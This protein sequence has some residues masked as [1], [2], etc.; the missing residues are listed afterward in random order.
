MVKKII[1][2]LIISSI[3]VSGFAQKMKKT[4][5]KA[6][7]H[8]FEMLINGEN[9]PAEKYAPGEFIHFDFDVLDSKFHSYTY[10]WFDSYYQTPIET[11]PIKLV[12]PM[13][14]ESAGMNTYTVTLS[15]DIR[16][17][18]NAKPIKQDIVAKINIDYKRTDIEVKVSPGDDIT[19]PTTSHGDITFKSVI[20]EVYTP[21]DTVYLEKG[22]LFLVRWHITP[23]TYIKKE[24]AVTSCGD[25]VWGDVTVARPSGFIGDFKTEVERFFPATNPGDLD[26]LKILT[27]TIVNNALLKTNFDPEDFCYDDNMSSFIL[28]ETNFNAFNW[29]YYKDGEKEKATTFTSSKT[30]LEIDNSGYYVVTGY[31]DTSLYKILPDLRISNQSITKEILIEDCELEIPNIIKPTQGDLF[32]I[33]KLNL[34]RENELT[35]TDRSGKVVFYQKNYNC[36]IKNRKYMNTENAF[37]GKTKDGK[38]LPYGAYAYELKYNAIP[39][40]QVHTGFIV[41]LKD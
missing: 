32:G 16:T 24:Y 36:I 6:T 11:A 1:L 25:V 15:F 41:I 40:I 37:S 23:Y 27:V 33:K 17:K 26:T 21:W 31:M 14:T 29:Q 35:I 3:T 8:Y 20:S 18:K 39:E 28:L 7:K 12:F 9:S 10:R 5:H 4:K 38:M 19:I 13:N 30:N 2:L 34:N 22:G